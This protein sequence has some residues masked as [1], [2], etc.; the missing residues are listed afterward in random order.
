MQAILDDL[1]LSLK[2]FVGN[3]LRSLLTL[4]G[5]VIGVATVIAMMALIEGL[6][7]Q[8]NDG[9]SFLGANGFE[10]S[11]FPAVNFGPM[12]WRKYARRKPLTTWDVLAIS[13]LPSVSAVAASIFEGGQ[14]VSTPW[15]ATRNNIP[16]LGGSAQLQA[17]NAL[18]IASG[19]FF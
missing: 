2:T 19:R 11:R 6:Q 8:V 7:G 10:V 4:L 13:E 14:K 18:T 5:I 1:R 15:A 9:L 17:T 3:P 12:N 16:V